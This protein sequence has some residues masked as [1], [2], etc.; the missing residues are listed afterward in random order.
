MTDS[1]NPDPLQLILARL[2]SMDARLESMDSRLTSLEQKVDERLHD[3]RP[4]WDALNSRLDALEQKFDGM[5]KDIRDIKEDFK[6]YRRR[7]R[8]DDGKMQDL[9]DR[10]LK[11][12]DENRQ[13]H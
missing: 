9:E 12:E 5:S 2:D 4:M 7:M 6:E 11:L 10:V 1:T 3:T 13:K 8:Y